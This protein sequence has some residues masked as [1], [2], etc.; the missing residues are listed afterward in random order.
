[1]CLSGLDIVENGITIIRD[2]FGRNSG[3][4]FVQ[5]SSQEAADEALQRDREF[6]GSRSDVDTQITFIYHV[7]PNGRFSYEQTRPSLGSS[8]LIDCC[9][10]LQ[11]HRGVSQ[12]K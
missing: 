11:I 12:Q 5:F 10:Y 2:H 1:M 4:A 7:W 9:L 3:E 6:M 8:Q